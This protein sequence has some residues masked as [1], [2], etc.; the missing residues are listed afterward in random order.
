[1]ISYIF[2]MILPFVIAHIHNDAQEIKSGSVYS[3]MKEHKK[4]TKTANLST[5]VVS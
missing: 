2:F 4:Q 5:C 1:M 3:K